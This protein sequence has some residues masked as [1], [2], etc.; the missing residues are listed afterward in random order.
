MLALHVERFYNLSDRLIQD[1][2][3]WLHDKGVLLYAVVHNQIS[4]QVQKVPR[5]CLNAH[6]GY[7]IFHRL[8]THQHAIR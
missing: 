7:L 6:Q 1:E 2:C 4:A 5:T 8:A 3:T